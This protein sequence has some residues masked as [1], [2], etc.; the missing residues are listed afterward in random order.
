MKS[1]QWLK[2]F[3]DFSKDVYLSDIE[4]RCIKSMYIYIRDIL[5]DYKKQA[6]IFYSKTGGDLSISDFTKKHYDVYKGVTLSGEKHSTL[7]IDFDFVDKQIKKTFGV[8]EDKFLISLIP[9]SGDAGIKSKT[10][11]TRIYGLEIGTT[12]LFNTPELTFKSTLQHEIQH[13][14]NLQKEGLEGSDFNSD[15]Y[16]YLTNKKEV[17]SHAKQFAYIYSKQFV[18]DTKIDFNKLRTM[19]LVQKSKEKLHLYLWF[20][21]PNEFRKKVQISDEIFQ[22]IKEAGELFWKRIN[23]YLNLLKNKI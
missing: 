1:L 18:Q 7:V 4:N 12:K 20:L 22:K 16:S 11:P 6:L 5:L 19:D 10:H 2:L 3:E 15:E 9:K 13:I 17:D 14:A 8:L 23:Y 21:S